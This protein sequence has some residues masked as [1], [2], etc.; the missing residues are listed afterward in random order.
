M[1]EGVIVAGLG[2]WKGW[3]DERNGVT[4]RGREGDA[5]KILVR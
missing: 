1:K 3:N 5:W 2:G 4:I